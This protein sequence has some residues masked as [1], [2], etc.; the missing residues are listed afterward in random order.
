M[1]SPVGSLQLFVKN[2]RKKIIIFYYQVMKKVFF[3]S[4]SHLDHE[5]IPVNTIIYGHDR[6]RSPDLTEN[7][8]M[9]AGMRC[10]RPGVH[11]W[12]IK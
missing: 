10:L 1:V 5:E 8:V 9:T 2:S 11:R 7:A 6:R 3:S 4:V 12:Q